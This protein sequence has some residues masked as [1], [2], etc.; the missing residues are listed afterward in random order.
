MLSFPTGEE[1]AHQVLND[2]RE[3]LVFLAVSTARAPDI[4]IY[5]DAGK[6]GAFER[7][8]NGTGVWEFYRRARTRPGY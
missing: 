4:C 8:P 6:L 2:G 5:P 3:T 7:G 1:G